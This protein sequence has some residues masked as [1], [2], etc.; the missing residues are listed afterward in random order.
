[1]PFLFT[2]IAEI[3]RSGRCGGGNVEV[4]SVA[5][6]DGDTAWAEGFAAMIRG[7]AVSEIDMGIVDVPCALN[8]VGFGG[9]PFRADLL[10]FDVALFPTFSSFMSLS[11]GRP[12]DIVFVGL[13]DRDAGDDGDDAL[14][15]VMENVSRVLSADPDTQV[16]IVSGVAS[17]DIMRFPELNDTGRVHVL[18]RPVV[19][20]GLRLTLYRAVSR[21][22]R[23]RERMIRIDSGNSMYMVFPGEIRYAESQRRILRVYADDVI[24]T[25]STISDFM[26]L[27]PSYFMQCHKSYLVNM[28]YVRMFTGTGIVLT[29]GEKIPVS[30]RRRSYT[31]SRLRGYV[32][33][34]DVARQ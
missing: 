28:N 31:K 26:L 17:R 16:V 30:Q 14:R 8:D 2:M 9:E 15:S 5:V 23:S 13:D 18:V 33:G 4:V 22:R 25:Y 19:L 6:I 32:R 12:S 1:M 21:L 34:L 29:T 11:A 10:T 7:L 27:L 3:E 20:E 24:E